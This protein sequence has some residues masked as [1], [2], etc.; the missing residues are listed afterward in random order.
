[1]DAT[2]DIYQQLA[3]RAGHNFLDALR[4][5]PEFKPRRGVYLGVLR[6]A[7]T[8]VDGPDLGFADTDPIN[9]G[10]LADI[11]ARRAEG[12]HLKHASATPATAP[13]GKPNLRLVGGA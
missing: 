13:V 5:L 2:R 11:T 7:I 10:D 12:L 4:A 9:L 1:M 6:V 8:V 3:A